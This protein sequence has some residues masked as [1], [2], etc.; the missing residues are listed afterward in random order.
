MNGKS[1][2]FWNAELETMLPQKM[3]ALQ[4]ERF[5][6]VVRWAYGKTP[7]YRRKLDEAGISA[8]QI[9]SLEDAVKI[10]FTY[11]DDLRASQERMPPYGEHCAL[12][13]KIYQTYWSTGTTGRPTFMGVSYREARYW[14]NVIARTLFSSGLRKGDSF[15]HA[16][17]L[18]SFAGGYGFLWAAQLIGANIIPAGA[19]NTERHIHLLCTL[20][21]SFLKILPS[22][23]NYVAEIGY[24][25]GIDMRASSVQHIYLS[26]EPAPPA[27]RGDLERKWGALTYDSYGLSDVGQPQTHECSLR[28][29]HHVIADWCLTEIVDPESK[30]PIHEEGREGVLV[31]TN[32]VRK[33]M[34]IIRFWTN[35]ISSWRS[36]EPCVC[37]RTSARIAPIQR[38]ID[39][40]VKVKGVN[41]WPSAVWTV[42]GGQTELTGMH[43]ILIETR[44]GKDYLKIILELKEGILVEAEKLVS[45]L[46][47]RL[48]S[49][50]FIKVDEIELVPF[51]SLQADEHKHRT[52]VDRRKAGVSSAC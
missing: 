2:E 43:R 23:A 40:V 47:T 26:A 9:R 34:P 29:G 45:A 4:E 8:S 6:S 25:K 11:K 24:K 15:H 19:G 31:F 39:D 1:Q 36:L 30:E 20:E 21:P 3:K 7:F 33:A 13:D 38:R 32:L 42:L 22:Y 12:P 18:S 28:D 35:D 10:P 51:G 41:F 50:L 44:G 48:Q 46:K 37:G 17:Q 5:L 49:A 52:M 14:V 16:T 27:L